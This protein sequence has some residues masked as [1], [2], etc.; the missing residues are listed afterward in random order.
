MKKYFTVTYKHSEAIYCANIVH[1]ETV[2][3]VKACYSKYEQVNIRES[4]Q[5]E[6]DAARRR[7]M[8]IVEIENQEDVAEKER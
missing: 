4:E 1:A 8:P 7:G 3:A 6:V 2:E 5:Y